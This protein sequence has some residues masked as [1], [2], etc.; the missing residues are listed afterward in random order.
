M[1]AYDAKSHLSTVPFGLT[2]SSSGWLPQSARGQYVK[3][4]QPTPKD[5]WMTDLRTPSAN[6]KARQSS[7]DED[8]MMNRYKKYLSPQASQANQLQKERF[9]FLI[10][11]GDFGTHKEDIVLEDG[12][13]IPRMCR[14]FGPNK[15]SKPMFQGERPASPKP[16]VVPP[17][18]PESHKKKVS[19]L[20]DTTDSFDSKSHP[21]AFKSHPKCKRAPSPISQDCMRFDSVELSSQ[22]GHEVWGDIAVKV[23]SKSKH[24]INN[25]MHKL[26]HDDKSSQNESIGHDARP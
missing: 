22:H 15:C 18:A 12:Q 1:S 10:Q 9:N 24:E 6:R 16:I 3:T 2:V 21:S 7:N 11:G 19:I 5:N 8:D 14:Y 17:K 23:I 4:F 25:F 13:N 26:A 20:E